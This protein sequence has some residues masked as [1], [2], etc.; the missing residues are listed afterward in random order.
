MQTLPQIS[1]ATTNE[2]LIVGRLVSDLLAAGL[3]I[4]VWN[5]G[6]E[7]ELTDSTNLE[8]ILAEL[9]ASD[10]DELTMDGPDGYAGWIRLVWGNDTAV[11]SD[12][13][14]RLETIMAPAHE[15]AD[16]LDSDA[17]LLPEDISLFLPSY[18]DALL[19]PD[20]ARVLFEISK[21]GRVVGIT[22]DY[23]FVLV[24]VFGNFVIYQHD[25]ATGDFNDAANF[26]P[27][28]P[29]C[30]LLNGHRYPCTG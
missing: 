24:K 5:G 17:R 3:S 13:S 28:C 1:H 11:I 12:Y 14:T 23:C 26:K 4:T 6:D 25:T 7:A 2:R 21:G 30:G 8:A 10:Q 18:E 27:E 16:L 22:E 20:K 15:L 29:R 19:D 9:A